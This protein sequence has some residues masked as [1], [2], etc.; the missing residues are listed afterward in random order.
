MNL[1]KSARRRKRVP[2]R[3]SLGRAQGIDPPDDPSRSEPSRAI[4]ASER[5]AQVHAALM[6]LAE[7][8]R[9]VIIMK[10]LEGMPYDEIAKT[11]QVPVGTVRSRLHRARLDLRDR[12]RGFVDFEDTSSETALEP[13]THRR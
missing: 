9:A 13:L 5:D 4:E 2:I 6:G 12:L 10:D 11:L 7:D 3:W 1:A 8:H